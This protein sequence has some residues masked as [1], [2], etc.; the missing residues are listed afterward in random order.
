MPFNTHLLDQ[1]LAERSEKFEQV[2]RQK[3][4]RLFDLLDE[5]GPQL[6]VDRAYVFGS[7]VRPH[8]FHE[9]SDVDVA[10]E[11]IGAEEFFTLIARLSAALEREVDVV[12]LRTCHFAERIR[13]IGTLWTRTGNSS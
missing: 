3:L 4:A 8:C 1:A 6:G 12:D 2:R 10:V 9:R 5:V 7:I 11:E 13:E